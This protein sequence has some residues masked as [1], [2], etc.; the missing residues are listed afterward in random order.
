MKKIKIEQTLLEDIYYVLMDQSLKLTDQMLETVDEKE[1]I[2]LIVESEKLD[3]RIEMLA[4]ILKIKP[5]PVGS[6]NDEL[7]LVHQ[8]VSSP[9][10]VD[11]EL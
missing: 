10:E 2:K 4:T 11:Q 5:E 7:K 3:A 6:S 9:F 1:K 8:Q